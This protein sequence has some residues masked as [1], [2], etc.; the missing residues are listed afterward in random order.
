MLAL[1]ALACLLPQEVS[2]TPFLLQPIESPARGSASL[3]SVVRGADGIVRMSWVEHGP[4]TETRLMLARF[5]EGGFGAAQEIAAGKDWFVNWADF[6]TTAALPDG[7]LLAAWMRRNGEGTFAYGIEFALSS[8]AGET[9]S[10]PCWLHNDRSQAE[11]G[12]VSLISL[13]EERFGAL[14]LDGGRTRAALK[15][16]A[17]PDA[18]QE[19]HW[20]TIGRDGSLGP[21]LRLDARACDC[22][23]TSLVRTTS[24][25]L[26]AAWRDRSTDEVRDIAFSRRA[27]SQGTD[28]PWSEPIRVHDDGWLIP[29]CP[30]NG[31]RLAAGPKGEL[32]CLWY[33]GGERLG[34]YAAF[35]R[36]ADEPHLGSLG[37]KNSPPGPTFGVPIRIDE[38]ATEGRVEALFL[39]DGSLLTL[40]M[41]H[42]DEGVQWRARSIGA[43]ASV[44]PAMTIAP[45]SSDRRMGFLRA[46]PLGDGA[47][48]A[49]K[50]PDRDGL[51]ILRLVP[52]PPRK[53]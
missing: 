26:F 45:T 32:A 48:L 25:D 37:H 24:G 29:G 49:W 20:R 6:P 33:T 40:W 11:H 1:F 41:E 13:D 5:S 30:V 51:A 2:P 15:E 22:C 17:G 42:R 53:D 47:L 12:F 14:W 3:P 36:G 39:A 7:T 23:Q 31:P 18:A 9:W 43:N 10:E 50:D 35:V 44:G 28:Q 8:D 52:S 34:T 4:D 19:V 46:A 21:E 16:A 27:L 38:G